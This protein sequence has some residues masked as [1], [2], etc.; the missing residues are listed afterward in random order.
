SRRARVPG[1]RPIPA[2]QK[3]ASRRIHSPSPLLP[4]ARPG[5]PTTTP[6]PVNCNLT[7]AP[8]PLARQG[9]LLRAPEQ[10]HWRPATTRRRRAAGVLTAASTISTIASAS[11]GR[12]NDD[13]PH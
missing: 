5:N 7:P 3:E 11:D 1:A 13:A 10:R 6:C 2:W 8:L 12:Y 4:H 9:R